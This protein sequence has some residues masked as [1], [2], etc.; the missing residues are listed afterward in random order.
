MSSFIGRKAIKESKEEQRWI[1]MEGRLEE[2]IM[3]HVEAHKFSFTLNPMGN[4]AHGP[5]SITFDLG[6]L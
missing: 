3:N 6:K 5:P 1:I 2:Y 4:Q